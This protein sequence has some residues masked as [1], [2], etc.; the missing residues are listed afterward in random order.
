MSEYT[1][2]LINNA[3]GKEELDIILNKC[4][5]ETEEKYKLLARLELAINF[6]EKPVIN[7]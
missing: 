3:R 5:K 7:T 6:K 1:V 2:K 4:G